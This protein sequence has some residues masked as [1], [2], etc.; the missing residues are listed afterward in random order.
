M[1]RPRHLTRRGGAFGVRFRIPRDLETALGRAEIRR[2][3]HT[4]DR[5]VAEHRCL[6]AT[7]WFRREVD[8]L[9][10]ASNPTRTDLER[11]AYDF[12]GRLKADLDQ[13]RHFDPDYFDLDVAQAAEHAKERIEQFDAELV[14]N[15]FGF[16]SS[17]S[18]DEMLAE[19]G[20]DASTL[21]PQSLFAARQLACRALRAQWQLYRHQLD[22]P[23]GQLADPDPLFADVHVVSHSLPLSASPVVARSKGPTLGMAVSE[24]LDAKR[25]TIGK[26][27][28]DE[29]TRAL[30]WLGEAL[31]EDTP[32]ATISKESLRGFRDDL[33]RINV[34]HRGRKRPFK[35][36]LTSVPDKQIKSQTYLRYWKSVQSL[37]RWSEAE[38]LRHDDPAAS[39]KLAARREDERRSPEP[40]S[41]QELRKLFQTPIFAGYRPPR[42]FTVQGDCHLRGAYWWFCVLALHTGLRA[43]E[44]SQLLPDDFDFEAAVSHLK[45]R[46]EDAS[47]AKVKQ[48]KTKASI[49]D[50]PLH[51]NLIELGLAEFVEKSRKRNPKAR[52]FEIFRLGQ[53]ERVSDGATKFWGRYYRKFG[54]HTHGRSTHVFRHTFAA[55]LRNAGATEEDLGALLGHAGAT[56]T[57]TYGG[58]Q[59]L[60]RKAK[61]LT[62]LDFGFDLVS[63]LTNIESPTKSQ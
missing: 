5:K 14:A 53:H 21:S 62:A 38:G 9:R 36:R 18:A 50:V 27:Q 2:S 15:Q 60:T 41:E 59:S 6:Q 57:S 45:V 20:I 17:A 12:F 11:A 39:L 42:S 19:A 51:P 63:A 30:G 44:I 35:E 1:S 4:S 55:T 54:L 49:R 23:A 37:F 46:E 13:P 29:I 32:L 26:S 24:Y 34:T 3:L 56:I 10:M 47:G 33:T 25:P 61:T 7:A 43:G 16:S 40:F 58:G 8:R 28:L 52:V 22:N 48:A 31:G